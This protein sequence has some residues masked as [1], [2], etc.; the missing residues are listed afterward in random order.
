M[1]RNIIECKST[2]INVDLSIHLVLIG[3]YW[4]VNSIKLVKELLGSS[5]NRNILEYKYR[6][7]TRNNDMKLT[8]I[9]NYGKIQT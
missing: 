8:N 3:T 5:I 9:Q 4:N 6:K 7:D 1:N 2:Y